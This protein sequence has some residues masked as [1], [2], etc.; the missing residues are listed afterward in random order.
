ME[1]AT[2]PMTRQ[3]IYNKVIVRSRLIVNVNKVFLNIPYNLVDGYSINKVCP[4]PIHVCASI[5]YVV[6]ELISL[7]GT[8]SACVLYSFKF[9]PSAAVL[10]C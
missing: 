9:P 8:F 1:R 4:C 5:T 6:Y 2:I 10:S 3:V 7:S